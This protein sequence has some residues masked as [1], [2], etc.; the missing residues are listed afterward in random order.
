MKYGTI[1]AD[2]NCTREFDIC[3]LRLCPH[4][5]TTA[6]TTTI[7]SSRTTRRTQG[8]FFLTLYRPHYVAVIRNQVTGLQTPVI[9]RSFSHECPVMDQNTGKQSK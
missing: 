8:S 6:T 9:S 5:P 3:F 2:N 1:E 4:P 7:T